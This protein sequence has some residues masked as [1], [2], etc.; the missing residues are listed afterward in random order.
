MEAV[1]IC[2]DYV[3]EIYSHIGLGAYKYLQTGE[4]ARTINY[5]DSDTLSLSRSHSMNAAYPQ[6]HDPS[7]WKP[8]LQKSK[9]LH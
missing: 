1:D 3:D 8:P 6:K 9:R 2:P 7:S 4:Y 5:T